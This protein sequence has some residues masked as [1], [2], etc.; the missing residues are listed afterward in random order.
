MLCWRRLPPVEESDQIWT[1]SDD[2]IHR[3]SLSASVWSGRSHSSRRARVS[4]ATASV[5]PRRRHASRYHHGRITDRR[6][7]SLDIDTGWKSSAFC[8]R[9]RREDVHHRR[10]RFPLPSAVGNAWEQRAERRRSMVGRSGIICEINSYRR[11]N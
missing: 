10:R 7:R 1:S 11:Y 8:R 6:S 9:H 2:D 4:L 3:L 5:Y